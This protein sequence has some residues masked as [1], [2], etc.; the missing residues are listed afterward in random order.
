GLDHSVLRLLES[1]I[2]TYHGGRVGL[3]TLAASLNEDPGTLEE[4]IEPY[5]LQIGFIKRSSQGRIATQRAYSHLGKTY[6]STQ[7]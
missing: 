7:K 6:T 5:L 1:I 4:V 2:E 3:T